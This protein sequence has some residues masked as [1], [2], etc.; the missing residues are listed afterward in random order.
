MSKL[1]RLS[2]ATRD[3]LAELLSLFI[4][5]DDGTPPIG[6]PLLLAL[7]KR[8]GLPQFGELVDDVIRLCPVGLFPA[9][10]GG[11]EHGL[12]AGPAG[13]VNVA[14]HVVAHE[15]DVFR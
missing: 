2:F 5:N 7:E 3:D 11:K 13:A 4:K 9:L 14:V 8:Y 15:K 6:R 1:F 10:V 12:H